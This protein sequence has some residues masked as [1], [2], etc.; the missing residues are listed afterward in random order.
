[1]LSGALASCLAVALVSCLATAASGERQATPRATERDLLGVWDLVSIEDH[2]PNGEVLFWLG[3]HPSGVL[4]YLPSGR[5]AVQF[6]RDPRPTFTA[7]RVWGRD[8]RELLPIAS[9]TEIREAFAGYYAY[10]GTYEVDERAQAVTHHVKASLRPHEVGLDY[11]RPF[12][13][14]GDRLVLRYPVTSDDN[15]IRTR[16]IVWRRAERL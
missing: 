11:V 7:G 4:T 8:G 14:S 13:L 6:M 2:K 3:Q 15:E 10:F 1:M 5:M 16:I 9:P 12:E